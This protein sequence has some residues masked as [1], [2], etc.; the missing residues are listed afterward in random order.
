MVRGYI[1]THGNCFIADGVG[2]TYNNLVFCRNV[3][4]KCMPWTNAPLIGRTEYRVH[5]IECIYTRQERD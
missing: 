5:N 4:K 1:P 3:Y 2:T